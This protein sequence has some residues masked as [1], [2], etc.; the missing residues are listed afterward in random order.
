M[1]RA[2]TRGAPEAHLLHGVNEFQRITAP[3]M[4]AVLAQLSEAGQSPSQLFIT[5]S[6]SRLVPA[7]MTASGP[8]DLFTVRNIGNLVPRRGKDGGL[9]GGDT[10]VASAIQYATEVLGVS[11]I[12]VCGHSGCGAMGALLDGTGAEAVGSPLDEW[13][14][15]GAHT[16]AR[17]RVDSAV[18]GEAGEGTDQA[19]LARLNVIQQLDNLLTHPVVSERVDSGAL[20]LTGMYFDIGEAEMYVLDAT[21]GT[22]APVGAKGTSVAGAGGERAPEAVTA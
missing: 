16:M 15:H 8:G 3:Q 18:D 10:S 5:C 11:S 22:F 7:L 14:R 1:G 21:S 6:D 17:F 9:D 19:R 20:R 13:L 12:T 2:T 4:R